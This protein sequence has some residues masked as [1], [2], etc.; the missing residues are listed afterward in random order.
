MSND[1]LAI[2]EQKC[3]IIPNRTNCFHSNKVKKMSKVNLD[4]LIPREDFEATGTNNPSEL[5]DTLS[6]PDFTSEFIRPFFRKPDFQ[7]ETSQWDTN[8]IC[9]FLESFVNEDLIPSIILWK[10]KS[11][12]YFVIDGAHRLGALRAW[13]YDDYG[14]GEIS[15]KFYE[16]DI[17][18]D[19]KEI[20][21]Y[22][23]KVIKK[24][25]GIYS[26]RAKDIGLRK[27]RVQ[28]VQGDATKAENSFFKINQQGVAVSKTEIKLL[29]SRKKPNCIAARAIWKAGKGHKFWADFPAENQSEIQRLSG[30][31]NKI[32]FTP[33]L[34]VPVKNL[35]LPIAGRISASLPL[36]FDFINIVNNVPTD[37]SKQLLDDVNGEETI[38]YLREVRKIA[39]RIN[40]VHPSS[41]GLDS[42]VYFYNLKGQH[43]ATSFRAVIVWILEMQKNNIFRDFTKVREQFEDLLLK[44]NDLIQDIGRKL[45]QSRES[46]DEIKDFYGE[47]LTSLSQGRNIDDAILGVIRN[48]KFKYLKLDHDNI[49]TTKVDFTTAIKSSAVIK[50]ALSTRLR[51][52][53]CG[54]R[55][56]ENAM[57]IDHKDRKEDGGIGEIENAQLAHPYCNTTYKG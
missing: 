52:K 14:D 13:I 32:L 41:L 33:P 30:E 51:C 46:Y 24:H 12:L 16:G 49:Q 42:I 27:L 5:G 44:Y 26:E 40:S 48:T 9:A 3:D 45:R 23:R 4:A 34:K 38:R 19:E 6:I 21:E 25:I 28:W 8:Q 31:I 55:L 10:S 47:C 11:G 1:D 56:H 57:T 35:H 37:F 2:H 22:T 43:K 36:I 20:A 17:S 50:E 54:A 29:Q 7:R 39:W 18:D 15:Q 53:I